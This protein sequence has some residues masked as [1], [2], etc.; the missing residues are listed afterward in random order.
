MAKSPDDEYMEELEKEIAELKTQLERVQNSDDHNF[1]R[2]QKCQ[3][4]L[5]ERETEIATYREVLETVKANTPEPYCAITRAVDYQVQKA[6]STPPS[7][8]YLEQWEK[9]RF[10]QVGEVKKYIGSLKDMAIIVWSGAQ[11]EE[12]TPLYTRKEK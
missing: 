10:V 12:G 8:C 7:T 3:E 2:W 6:L 4:Q 11:P 5:A 1:D 9:D